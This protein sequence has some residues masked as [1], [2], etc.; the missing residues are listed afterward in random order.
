MTWPIDVQ[1]LE[2]AIV[3]N[4]SPTLAALKPASL[5]TFP[6]SF[7]AEAPENQNEA[8]ARR[9]ALLEAVKYCQRQVSN[10]G[11]AI[12]ILA[13][14]RCGALVYV[15]RPRELA[16]YLVDRRAAHPLENE[17]YRPG[18][19]DA[20]LDELSRRLQNRSSESAKQGAKRVHDESKPCPCSNRV[21]RSEFPHE[22]GFFLGYPYEDVIGFIKNRGQNYLEVGPWKVY[23]NQNQARRTFA[24]Y[25]R[26]AR[27]YARA[28]RSGQSLRRLAV[29]PAASRRN[30]TRPQH[31]QR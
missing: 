6:G 27:I 9:Q 21:C 28:Y 12:R 29:S 13:W 22:I 20:C 3:R 19:L 17:G 26:C 11:V 30:A 4:C 24:R 14:K 18:D 31:V 16:A 1:A 23:A 7:T 10:A 15:Y 25:R 2:Q 8:S 5:F